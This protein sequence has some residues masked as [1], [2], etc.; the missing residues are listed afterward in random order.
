M[1][2]YVDPVEMERV[3]RSVLKEYMLEENSDTIRLRIIYAIYQKIPKGPAFQVLCD[4]HN[5]HYDVRKAKQY[6]VDVY[7]NDKEGKLFCM[8][9]HCD[10][11]REL[12]VEEAIKV[13]ALHAQNSQNA[14]ELLRN[15]SGAFD[16]SR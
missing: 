14:E 11:L 12:T 7:Y 16:P 8:E 10:P 3:V 4:S 6:H 15:K 9:F 2:E 1:T 13:N 5:N